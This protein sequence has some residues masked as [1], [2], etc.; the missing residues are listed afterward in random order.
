MKARDEIREYISH[1]VYGYDVSTK[2]KKI[3]L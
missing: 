1:K 3:K 2:E